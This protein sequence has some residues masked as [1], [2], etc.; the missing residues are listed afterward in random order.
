MEDMEKKAMINNEEFQ[1]RSTDRILF[2]HKDIIRFNEDK[3]IYEFVQFPSDE[4]LDEMREQLTNE[5]EA[6]M[7]KDFA[8]IRERV[9][10]QKA[11]SV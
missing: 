6:E 11:I 5:E 7:D 8:R 1:K 3:N 10:E 9:A 2:T 4:M